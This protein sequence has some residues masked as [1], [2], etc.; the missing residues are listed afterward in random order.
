MIFGLND[1][2]SAVL[3]VRTETLQTFTDRE[4]AL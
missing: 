4:L 2:K 1:T 3:V